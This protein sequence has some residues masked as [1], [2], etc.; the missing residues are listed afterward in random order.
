MNQSASKCLVTSPSIR[1]PVSVRGQQVTSQSPQRI[2][3]QRPRPP[4]S[5]S[6]TTRPPSSSN[7]SS[8]AIQASPSLCTPLS[9]LLPLR[10]SRPPAIRTRR[11]PRFPLEKFAELAVLFEP[12]LLRDLAKRLCRGPKQQLRPL[13]LH[14]AKR[15][16]WSRKGGSRGHVSPSLEAVGEAPALS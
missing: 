14:S 13:R 4:P 8:V 3:H 9:S 1:G 7:P 11:H 16:R 10:I 12:N 2:N 5:N 6:A 15:D